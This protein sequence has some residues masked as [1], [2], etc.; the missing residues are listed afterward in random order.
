MIIIRELSVIMRGNIESDNN[1]HRLL[2]HRLASG[3]EWN[4][5]RTFCNRCRLL[6]KQ[7]SSNRLAWRTFNASICHVSYRNYSNIGAQVTQILL[8]LI[9]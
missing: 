9:D 7:N 5:P 4:L 1:F 8:Q 6:G 2:I 3:F